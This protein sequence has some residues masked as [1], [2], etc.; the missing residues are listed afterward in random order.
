VS[1][2]GTVTH[3][4]RY[5]V[6]SMAGVSIDAASLGWYGLEGDRRHAFRLTAAR[7]GFPFLTASRLNELVLYQPFGPPESVLPT[8]VRTPDGL[9]LE[10]SSAELRD[11]LSARH[12]EA[13][14]L[15]RLDHGIFDETPVSVICGSTIRGIER[16]AERPLDVRR[17]RPNVIVE[18]PGAE[19]FAEDMWVGK[20]LLLGDRADGPAVTVTLRDL[21]C[22]MVNLDP[23]TAERDARVMK[24]TARLNQNCAGVYGTVVREGRVFVGQKVYLSE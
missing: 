4:F 5:P 14:E 2:I 12:G 19:P 23:D 7:S 17:F 10:L 11:A 15:M 21:R 16:E 18:I 6:K 9:E 8:H 13:V 22:V 24:T 1:E 3:L 20:T